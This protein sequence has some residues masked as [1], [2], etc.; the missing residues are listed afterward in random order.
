MLLEAEKQLLKLTWSAKGKV[1]K[2]NKMETLWS[3]YWIEVSDK[4]PQRTQDK[5]QA[6]KGRQFT[7]KYLQEK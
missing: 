7:E 3:A 4:L 1:L 6:F 5:T 2:F